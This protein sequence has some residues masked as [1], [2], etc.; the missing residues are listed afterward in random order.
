MG[1][2]VMESCRDILVSGLASLNMNL[3]EDQVEQLLGFI[4][5]IEKWN[6]AYNLTAIRDKEDMV[7][8][9]LLD[10][11][12]VLP[13]VEGRRVI[14]I[15]TGAGLPGIPLAICLPQIE[16]TL[17]DSNAKKT[18]FVQQVVLELGL[19]NVAICHN[20]VE[21]Y[22]PGHAFNTV[23][24]RAFASLSDIVELTA[25]LLAEGGMLLAMKGPYVEA[26]LAEVSAD[27]TLIPI[28]V[29]GVE[30]ERCLVRIRPVHTR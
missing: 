7:R 1:N 30:A 15:G 2:A 18:R 19:K 5:L 13:F 20:R 28:K 11:L 14:D 8:L 24:T 26:E 16:F 25:H 9:H 29:P 10:S 4:K 23:I 17:L 12:A 3:T 27:K 22:Q 6:K 21:Q